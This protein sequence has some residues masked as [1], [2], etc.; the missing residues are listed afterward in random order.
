[1]D[2]VKKLIAL[3]CLASVASAQTYYNKTTIQPGS[4]IYSD[5]YSNIFAKGLF[6]TQTLVLPGTYTRCT[7]PQNI[8][9]A[10]TSLTGSTVSGNYSAVDYLFTANGFANNSSSALVNALGVEMDAG[11]TSNVG[12][13]SGFYSKVKQTAL[14]GNFAAGK[15]SN[16]AGATFEVRGNANEGGTTG[17]GNGW[18]TIFGF[19][20]TVYLNPGATFWRGLTG[21]EIDIT[22]A[23]GSSVENIIGLHIVQTDSSVVAGS[24]ENIGFDF[25]NG[26]TA[27]G[28]DIGFSFGN[29]DGYFPMASTGTLIGCYRHAGSG[30]SCGTTTN[31]VDF[32][33]GSSSKVIFTGKA[34]RSTGF[35]VDGSGK[36]TS[37]TQVIAPGSSLSQATWGTLGIGL[38]VGANASFNDTTTGSGTVAENAAYAFQA[39]TFTNTQ[40]T[41]NT[42]T[43]ADTLYVA[44]PVC[45]SGWTACTNLYAISTP[46][47]IFGTGGAALRGAGVDIN[48]NSNFATTIGTGTSNGLVTIGGGS[49]AVTVNATT[50]TLTGTLAGTSISTY[51]ASPPAI[52]GTVAAAG[53][54]TTLGSS[55]LHTATAG[56]T[57]TGADTNINASSN[58]NTNIGT[59]TTT[60][61]VTIGQNSATPGAVAIKGP[62]S[63]QAST[64]YSAASWLTTSPVFNGVA[65]TLNDTTA[66]GTVANDVAYSLQAPNFTSTGGA[67]TTLTNA[68]NLYLFAPTCSGGL[69]CSNLYSLNTP[70]RVNITGGGN[71]TGVLNLNVSNNAASNIGTGSTSSNVS[72]GNG[73]NL[74]TLGPTQITTGT[75][76]TLGNFSGCGT[77]NGTPTTLS[78]GPQGGSFVTASSGTTCSVV[79]TINGA[80]GKTASHGW[81]CWGSDITS[82]VALAQSA[83]TTTTCTLKGTI[84]AT[85]DTVVFM[86]MGY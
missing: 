84:N 68:T 10:T 20:P 71:Y 47:K 46:G 44:A 69:V 19:N 41:A 21:G 59:G 51:L 70:G 12:G 67:S 22:A 15:I 39:P 62:V 7:A 64:N 65:M 32:D 81:A 50:L 72:I 1:M 31:G 49:N 25:D 9:C 38:T 24:R 43:N 16:W 14:T 66:S 37:L 58:F 76:F 73:A 55:S 11:G 52:G 2:H 53:S 34:F 4:N 3:L 78:G 61:T 26:S 13:F 6:A 30:T 45:G 57:V 85:T 5:S 48:L 27:A 35:S 42:L 75:V 56:M 54:F 17:S 28:W 40:G 36:L 18:G 33:N 60:G 74:N 83:T 80:T 23:S 29:Y 82:A 77:T 86:A 63:F 8:L 79:I